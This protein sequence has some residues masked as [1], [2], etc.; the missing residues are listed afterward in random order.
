[1]VAPSGLEP[2]RPKTTDF[3]SAASTNFAKGPQCEPIVSQTP[4]KNYLT[5][6]DTFNNIKIYI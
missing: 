4:F 2:E 3:K 1:M 5:R 6:F